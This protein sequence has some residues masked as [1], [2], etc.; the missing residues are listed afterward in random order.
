[1]DTAEWPGLISI[2]NT[3]RLGVMRQILV[4][5]MLVFKILLLEVRI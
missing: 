2:S 5:Q 1:M 4:I 3:I